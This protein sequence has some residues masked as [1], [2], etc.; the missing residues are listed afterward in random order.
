MFSW[1][2]LVFFLT[3]AC[4]R[5]D[6]V[7]LLNGDRIS[8]G[9]QELDDGKLV[10]KSEMMGAVTLPWKNVATI[11]STQPL[12]VVL[13]NGR[14]LTGALT[15][16]DQGFVLQN[17]E[18]V[19]RLK[20]DEIAVIRSFEQQS[21]WQRAEER[22]LAPHFLDPWQGAV[23]L[24][25]SLA[26]GNADVTTYSTGLNG[27]R[28]TPK[29]KLSVNFTSLY[30]RNEAQSSTAATADVIRGGGRYEMNIGQRQF[31]FVSAD[32]E[33]DQLQ[34][35][36]LRSVEGAGFGRHVVNNRRHVFD[37]FAG[38]TINRE[39]FATGLTRVAGEALFSEESNHKLNGTF[40]LKQRLAMFPNLTDVGAYR[41]AFDG[42]AV[43]TLMEWLSWQVTLSDRYL[44]TP[45]P[46]TVPNDLIVTTGFRFSLLPHR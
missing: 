12:Y 38:A 29:G 22:R 5:A 44:S 23:D 11:I 39:A 24:G 42:T 26:R 10:L 25:F 27:V 13:E 16:T 6:Q 31:A 1:R 3:I 35:L 41:V 34:K 19:V 33:Y 7:V 20:R 8:G 21:E 4:T 37:L 18:R 45:L 36:D 30:S 46:G 43:T 28:T 9:I 40:A 15:Q 14:V 2:T 17:S 32:F